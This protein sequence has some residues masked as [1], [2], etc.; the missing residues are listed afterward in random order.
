VLTKLGCGIDLGL[1]FLLIS[2]NLVMI[3]RLTVGVPDTLKLIRALLSIPIT[4]LS[5]FNVMFMREPHVLGGQLLI[6][7][8]FN[9]QVAANFISEISKN[10]LQLFI[11]HYLL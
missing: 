7:F 2:D 5:L 11:F 6:L 3:E 9:V 8:H 4:R 10:G 1:K